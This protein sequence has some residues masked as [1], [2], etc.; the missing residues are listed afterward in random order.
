MTPATASGAVVALALVLAVLASWR[1]AHMV[2]LEDGPASVFSRLR[3]WYGQKDWI[4]RGL[5]C[6]LCLSF[7]AALPAAAYLVWRF[8][9][10]VWDL[11]LVWGGIAGGVL[12]LHK[13]ST[14]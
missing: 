7:W 6:V 8:A 14:R 13:W 1:A 9:L 3:Y 10:P 12:A 5:H 11:P 4:G 2:A